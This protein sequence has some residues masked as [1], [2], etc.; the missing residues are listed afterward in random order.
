M[1]IRDSPSTGPTPTPIGQ[2]VQSLTLINADTD[3]PI[4]AYDPIE[5]GVKIKLSTLPTNRLNIRA[6]TFPAL[7]G[8]LKFGYD[9]H[10]SFQ[11]E[12]IAPYAF[13]GDEFGN[14]AAWT[15]TLGE[16]TVIATPFS[17]Q[18]TS[19]TLGTALIRKF[20]IEN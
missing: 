10:G 6:N 19:G 9:A 7:V 14:Y 11:I 4:V 15:P 20:T 1:C 16:H 12:N 2:Y 18:N 17:G 5:E 8:S 13:A 3:L